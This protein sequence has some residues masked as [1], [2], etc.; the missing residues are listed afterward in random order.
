MAASADLVSSGLQV[1]SLSLL[2]IDAR[3]TIPTHS[4]WQ[5]N[6]SIEEV[7][8]VVK[9]FSIANIPQSPNLLCTVHP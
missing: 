8:A 1:S 9:R 3:S 7:Q 5:T 4:L 2:R 6:I